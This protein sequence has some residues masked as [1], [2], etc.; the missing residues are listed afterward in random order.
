MSGTYMACTAPGCYALSGKL[1]F[2]TVNTVL[3]ENSKVFDRNASEENESLSIDLSG[4]E[5]VDSAG[6]ALLVELI[7]RAKRSNVTISFSNASAQMQVLVKVNGLES[8]IPIA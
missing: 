1:T 2:S 3:A 8:I 7:K 6:L 5:L 4:V